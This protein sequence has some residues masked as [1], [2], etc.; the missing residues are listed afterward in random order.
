[1][2]PGDF[3]KY[4]M[5]KEAI[6]F[7]SAPTMFDTGAFRPSIIQQQA[8]E[9]AMG[10]GQM[11]GALRGG[12]EGALIGGGSGAGIGAAGGGKPL[13][14]LGGLWGAGAGGLGGALH[15]WDVGGAKAR[16][17]FLSG[18]EQKYLAE[19]AARR[20]AAGS[21]HGSVDELARKLM[22]AGEAG[23]QG[24]RDL[25]SGAQAGMG[26]MQAGASE[27]LG[28]LPPGALRKGM[29]AGGAGLGAM[30]LY[31]MMQGGQQ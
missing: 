15:G 6:I 21:M 14:A 24:V 16:N 22:G 27:M 5:T 20:G 11:F 8:A 19:Q 18:L 31:K 9:K 26:R 12:L 28:K 1:M 30:A 23:V 25:A 2:K 4:A 7:E 3:S 13:A 10:R 17:E 29:M